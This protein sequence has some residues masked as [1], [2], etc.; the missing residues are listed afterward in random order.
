MLNN[1]TQRNLNRVNK[2]NKEYYNEFEIIKK[3]LEDSNLTYYVY[4]DNIGI[5]LKDIIIKQTKNIP[6][7][8]RTYADKYIKDMKGIDIYSKE[9]SLIGIQVEGIVLYNAI[10][11]FYALNYLLLSIF[12]IGHMNKLLNLELVLAIIGTCFFIHLQEKR[13][14]LCNEYGFSLIYKYFDII[15]LIV[16]M[17]L[18]VFVVCI[19]PNNIYYINVLLLLSYMVIQLISFKKEIKDLV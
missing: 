11:G 14:R 5:I 15:Y 8:G 13:F 18:E 16:Y 7:D 6:L 3:I 2:L 4:N 19:W 1:L 10:V 17:I 12:N 9:V